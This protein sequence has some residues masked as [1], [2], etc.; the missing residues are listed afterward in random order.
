MIA[1]ALFADDGEAN[2]A[3]LDWLI[4]DLDDFLNRAGAR[5]RLVFA[6]CVAVL[7]L[8]APLWIGRFTTLSDLPLAER[9]RALHKAEGGLL[10][11]PALAAKAILC[12]LWFEHPDV[13]REERAR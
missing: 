10:G 4:R 2:A 6:L 12:I 5:P 9:S 3:R 11:P 8:F 1:E 7:S 13:D